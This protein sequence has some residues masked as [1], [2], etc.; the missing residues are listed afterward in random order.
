MLALATPAPASPADCY[1]TGCLFVLVLFGTKFCALLKV[2]YFH[3]ALVLYVPCH[4][5]ISQNRLLLID[6]GILHVVPVTNRVTK[7]KES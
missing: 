3:M 4:Q 1:K 2:G 5:E 7:V 6:L